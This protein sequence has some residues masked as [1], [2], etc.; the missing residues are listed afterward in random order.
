MVRTRRGGI[1]ESFMLHEN[2][3][4]RRRR[5]PQKLPRFSWAFMKKNS[6]RVNF[7]VKKPEHVELY[8]QNK[9]KGYPM[10]MESVIHHY[11]LSTS[12]HKQLN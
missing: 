3:K 11:M 9:N 7:A 10:G 4:L 12:K 6:R 8:C 1:A 2:G 5:T